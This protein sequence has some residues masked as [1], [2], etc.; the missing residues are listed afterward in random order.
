LAVGVLPYRDPRVG[1]WCRFWRTT[2]DD[3]ATPDLGHR[4]GNQIDPPAESTYLVSARMSQVTLPGAALVP[5]CRGLTGPV[6]ACEPV[7]QLGLC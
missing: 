5:E 6:T 4:K 1:A 7:S 2:T 3:Q